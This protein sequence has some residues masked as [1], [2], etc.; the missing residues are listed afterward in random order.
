MP[1]PASDNAEIIEALKYHIDVE[2]HG[3]QAEAAR[4]SGMTAS[5]LS[6]L[7]SGDVAPTTTTLLRIAKGLNMPLAKLLTGPP[8]AVAQDRLL[9][10]DMD[11]EVRRFFERWHEMP[12][13]VKMWTKVTLHMIQESI[14]DRQDHNKERG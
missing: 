10:K 6:R 7:L 4:R 5:A 1:I 3:N 2:C 13:E 8:S 12:P 14:L 11:P 9:P